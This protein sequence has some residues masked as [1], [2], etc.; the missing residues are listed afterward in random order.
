MALNF[1]DS[2]IVE[3]FH[4]K[5]GDAFQELKKL[6]KEKKSFDLVILDPPAFAKKK[7]EKPNAFKAYSK[8]SE[9]GAYLVKQ[10]GILFAASCSAP[11]SSSEFFEIVAKGV[12]TAGFNFIPFKKSGHAIDHP[13]SFKEGGYLKGIFGNVI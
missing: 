10:G 5:R 7:S 4:Q 9:M 3:S 11:V 13:I 12:R 8:L 2:K 6:K 1:P